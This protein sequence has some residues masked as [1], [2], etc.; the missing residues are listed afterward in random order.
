M[1]FKLFQLFNII[2]FKLH[3]N[4][5]SQRKVKISLQNWILVLILNLLG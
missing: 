1:M 3:M 2:L 4:L 5:F